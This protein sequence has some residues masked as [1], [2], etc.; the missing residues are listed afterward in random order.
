MCSSPPSGADVEL[1]TQLERV[2]ADC[3]GWAMSCCNRDRDDAEEVL[4][5]VYL[6]VLDG[7]ARY[8][9]RSSF[10]TWIFGVIRRTAASER[11]KA[12]LR[13]L[14]VEREGGRGKG[15][16]G[17]LNPEPIVS[18]DV[19]VEDQSR[20][21]GLRHALAQLSARQREV[22]QLVFYHDLTVEEAASAMGVSLGSART[23][24]ARGKAKLA[25]MLGDGKNL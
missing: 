18:P 9:A 10:R 12:W 16:V 21:D 22:L 23:H 6:S 5:T 4:Q 2:H 24:Y 3:F 15:E 8:D 7:R 17:L 20:R 19:E 11:R 13:G 14:V 25:V 1:R